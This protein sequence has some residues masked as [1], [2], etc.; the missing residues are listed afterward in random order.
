MST[1]EKYK[2]NGGALKDGDFVE[3]RCGIGNC[4]PS[5]L[6]RINNPK[7][8]CLCICMYI[9]VQGKHISYILSLC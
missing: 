1:E 4:R 8:L 6:Q 9:T 3:T 5:W 7:I 2:E